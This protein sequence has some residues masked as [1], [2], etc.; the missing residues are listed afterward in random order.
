VTARD[1][2]AVSGARGVTLSALAERFDR[3]A[4]HGQFVLGRS[5]ED[6]PAGWPV[7]AK[8]GWTLA[9]HPALPVHALH[10]ADG[11]SIGWLLGFPLDV[12]RRSVAADLTLATVADG[13]PRDFEERLYALGGKFLAI[14]L[15]PRAERVYLDSAGSLPAVFAPSLGLVA[16]T[17]SLIPFA[18]GC[19][20]DVDLIRATGLPAGRNGQSFALAFGLT[21]RRGVERL[22]PNHVL[23]LAAWTASRHW[24][25]APLDAEVDP[26]TAVD[27]VT[28]IVEGGIAAA[29]SG[30]PAYLPLTGGHDSRTLLACARPYLDR[31][32]LFTLAFADRSARFD[33]VVARRLARRHGLRHD[34]MACDPPD[35][36][37]V[38]GW[39]WR[40]GLCVGGAR[41]WQAIRARRRLDPSHA[42]LNGLG[43]EAA[44]AA[45]WKDLGG[46]AVPPTPHALV[47]ALALPPV[48]D[49]LARARKWLDT[50]PASRFMH[51]VDLLYIEQRVGCWSGVVSYADATPRR[52]HPFVHRASFTA[53]L[54]LPDDYKRSGRF[55]RDV[56]ASRWPELLRDPINRLPG[57]RHHL[58][59]AKRGVWLAR[60]AWL[61][62]ERN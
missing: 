48:P 15:A 9:S 43:G 21:S 33:V 3:N 18:R 16:S 10:A 14:L 12:Q 17:P 13:S 46:D 40:S 34:V 36:S 2:Q 45:Y 41:G 20:D 1:L 11:A 8:R 49:L 4:L 6:V 39:L 35:E 30:A 29:V 53:M 19:E 44:R 38:D 54:Q 56:I 24:P 47:R 25:A 5:P 50:L 51:V 55:P 23:D 59:R 7:H 42:E 27:Q 62:R 60:R 31:L 58:H 37:E 52:L 57:W 61:E 22:L 32:S 26:R 28:R